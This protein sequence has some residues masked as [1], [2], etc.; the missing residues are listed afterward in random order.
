MIA[1]LW[2]GATRTDDA[3]GYEDYM[4]AHAL[5]GYSGTAG[6]RGVLMLRR[7]LPG[8]RSEFTMVSLWEDMDAVRAFAGD[9]PE[10]AVFYPEDDRFL[11]ER[12]LTVRHY[13]VYGAT[14]GWGDA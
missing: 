3:A 6:N 2:T 9:D 10:T 4:R 13:D 5:P 12:E 8:G 7:D 1:R 14:P 11:V